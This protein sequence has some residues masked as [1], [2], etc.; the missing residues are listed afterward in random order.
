LLVK[1]ALS[2][3]NNLRFAG[4]DGA[5]TRKQSAFRNYVSS[6]TGSRFTPEAGRYHVYLSLTCPWEHRVLFYLQ[7]KGL[8]KDFDPAT[9][10]VSQDSIIGLSVVQ[11]SMDSKGRRFPSG[12]DPCVAA[13]PEP[14]YGFK[15]LFDLYYKADP[16]YDGRFSVPVFWDK[17]TETIVNNESTEIIRFLNSEY[18]DLIE[19]PEKKT[20][21]YVH[22]NYFRKSTK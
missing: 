2:P 21:D 1:T 5:F 13:I 8:I 12:D 6:K 11:W 10:A 9:S 3:E 18:N 7:T 14:L 17:K 20:L 19:D 22:L 4:K 15:R 16:V